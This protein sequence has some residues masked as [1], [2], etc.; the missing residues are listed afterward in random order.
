MVLNLTNLGSQTQRV[1]SCSWQ[2]ILVFIFALGSTIASAASDT[3]QTFSSADGAVGALVMAAKT[4]DMKALNAILGPAAGKIL[5]SGDRVADNNARENFVRQYQ[6]MHRL[7]YDD[8]G[9]VILYIGA[10]NW[11]MPIPLIKTDDGWLFDTTAGTEELLYRRIGQNELSTI[12]VLEDLADAQ[13]EYVSQVHIG[14]ETRQFARKILSNPGQQDGLYWPAASGEQQSP[15][16]PL[17]ANAT[18]EGYRQSS[19]GGASPFHGYYYKVLTRQGPHAPGGAKSYLVNGKMI[20]GFAFLAYPADY[21]SSGVMT[22]MINQDGIIV[23]KDL[24]PDTEAIAKEIVEFNPDRS[25]SQD[26]E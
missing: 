1:Y 23:Q 16:G 10:D 14:D 17:I 7:A 8:Q 12:G 15:I 22:F 26:V 21:R 4:D 6:A 9:R 20:R 3:Q 18:T 19:G 13:Q 24:G 5:S 25:W 11:P 2:I